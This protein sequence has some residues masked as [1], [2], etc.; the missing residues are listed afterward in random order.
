MADLSQLMQMAPM[1][2]AHF[3]GINQGQS[4]QSEQLKMM[5]LQQLMQTRAQEAQQNAAMNPLKQEQMRLQNQ[6]TQ[7]QLPGIGADAELKAYKAKIAK[8][9]MGSDIE[10]DQV[11][12][13][14]KVYKTIGSTL[15]SVAGSIEANSS[16][17]PHTA[18]AS[19]LQSMGIP[20]EAAQRM[21]KKYA[22]VPAGQLAA[23]LRKDSE[24]MLRQSESYVREI[25]Q[26][27]LKQAGSTERAKLLAQNRVDVKGMGGAGGKTPAADDL[28][29]W[30]M[31]ELKGKPPAT[32]L[33]I[34]NQYIQRA[35]AQGNEE[36]ANRLREEAKVVA[37][38]IAT[39]PNAQPNPGAP[40]IGAASG[41]R[42]PVYETQTPFVQGEGQQPPATPQAPDANKLRKGIAAAGWPYEP[43]KYDY[44]IAPDGVV[45]RK[46]K[47]K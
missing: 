36:L 29:G 43:N 11:E 44:R 15:G 9:T 20:D 24:N 3:A 33:A 5:E 38:T 12:K 13:K 31:V 26:E 4:E 10:A 21:L 34:L 14:M 23:R 17:P 35:D 39:L 1:V 32:R 45:E 42:V 18:F 47:G 40:N 8:E 6:T 16:V 7:A 41:G 2:G 46:P 37:Q 25:D 30:L 19:E 22:D 27:K 28:I